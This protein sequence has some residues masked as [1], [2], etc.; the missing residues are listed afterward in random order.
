MKGNKMEER[1]LDNL[2]NTFNTFTLISIHD[3]LTSNNNIDKIPFPVIDNAEDYAI[4]ICESFEKKYNLKL[5]Y[6][7][8]DDIC[9]F[10]LDKK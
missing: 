7:I 3:T 1:N 6:E 10:S 4:K 5:D 9:Y 2:V 8:K